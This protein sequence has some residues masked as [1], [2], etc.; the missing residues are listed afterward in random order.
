MLVVLS[1]FSYYLILFCQARLAELCGIDIGDTEFA[2][3]KKTDQ[4]VVALET[5]RQLFLGNRVD[6]ECMLSHWQGV[7]EGTTYSVHFEG[8]SQR[9]GNHRE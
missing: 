1:M 6:M 3:P 2:V 5:V 9:S 4:S 8:G 7:R